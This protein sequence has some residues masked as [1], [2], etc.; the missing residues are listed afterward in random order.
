MPYYPRAVASLD[1]LSDVAITSSTGGE[2]LE[3]DGTNYVDRNLGLGLFGGL[4][5]SGALYET[6]PR[7]FAN[8]NIGALAS[9]RLSLFAIDLPKGL[10]ITNISFWSATTALSTGVNQLF[11]LY[12]SSRVLLRGS[13]DGTNGAWGARTEKTLAL[14][15][16][17]TTTYSGL[18]YVGILVNATTVP[19]L[20]GSPTLTWGDLCAAAPTL[21]GTS[22]TSVTALPDP[23]GAI[24]QQGNNIY[25]YV[26]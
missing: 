14:T 21:F 11:G 5:R 1:N 12:D 20:L 25:C 3:F 26:S 10:L 19:S 18:H 9:Q 16:Q 8:Q 7:M 23:A 24:T 13:N 17:F 6:M 2:W 4:R 15:S 22:S